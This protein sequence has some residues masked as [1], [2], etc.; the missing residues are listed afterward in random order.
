MRSANRAA[1]LDTTQGAAPP[2][3]QLRAHL[4]PNFLDQP[5]LRW[6]NL[7]TGPAIFEQGS[8]V[9]RTSTLD[10]PLDWATL[11]SATDTHSRYQEHHVF[12]LRTSGAELTGW[13]QPRY[14]SQYIPARL[15]DVTKAMPS[16]LFDIRRVALTLQVAIPDAVHILEAANFARTTDAIRMDPIARNLKLAAMRNDRLIRGGRPAFS[17]AYVLRDVIASER[18]ESVDVRE[19]LAP[20]SR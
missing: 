3:A 15:A 10:P 4:L 11:T 9:I 12:P 20:K 8:W 5:L 2:V 19:W 7:V 18:I 17:E 6:R 1:R 13:M 16:D 14:R